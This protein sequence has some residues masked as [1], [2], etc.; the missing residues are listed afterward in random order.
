MKYTTQ[1]MAMRKRAQTEKNTQETDMLYYIYIILIVVVVFVVFV[2]FNLLD[3][4][5]NYRE[6][7]RLKRYL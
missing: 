5:E 2:I 4:T 1:N 6:L 7:L 3:S